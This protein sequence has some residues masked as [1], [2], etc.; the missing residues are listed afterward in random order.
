MNLPPP[1]KPRTRIITDTTPTYTQHRLIRTKFS[2]II[3][4]LDK[5]RASPRLPLAHPVHPRQKPPRTPPATNSTFTLREQSEIPAPIQ[6]GKPFPRKRIRTY[7][8]LFFPVASLLLTIIPTRQ[9]NADPFT[10]A[11]IG[12]GLISQMIQLST[13]GSNPTATFAKHNH[14]MLKLLNDRLT[15]QGV[16]LK[17]ISEQ[18]STLPKQVQTIF[19]QQSGINLRA[20]MTQIA[21]TLRIMKRL[22][23]KNKPLT[24]TL[25]DLK[26]QVDRFYDRIHT[27]IHQDSH[28][29][30]DLLPATYVLDALITFLYGHDPTSLQINRSEDIG[31]IIERIT[32]EL[33]PA[34]ASDLNH[35]TLFDLYHKELLSNQTF[36]INFN[37]FLAPRL[38]NALSETL[39]YRQIIPKDSYKNNK[40]RICIVGTKTSLNPSFD[41]DNLQT[42]YDDQ[43]KIAKRNDLSIT[44]YTF[45]LKLLHYETFIWSS[46][47]RLSEPPMP[48]FVSSSPKSPPGTSYARIKNDALYLG[49]AVAHSVDDDHIVYVSSGNKFYILNPDYEAQLLRDRESIEWQPTGHEATFGN[50]AEF[51]EKFGIAQMMHYPQMRLVAGLDHTYEESETFLARRVSVIEHAIATD[52]TLELAKQIQHTTIPYPILE[53][54]DEPGNGEQQILNQIAFWSYSDHPRYFPMFNGELRINREANWLGRTFGFSAPS[55]RG[56]LPEFHEWFEYYVDSWNKEIIKGSIG[57]DVVW[58]ASIGKDVKNDVEKKIKVFLAELTSTF[59]TEHAVLHDLGVAHDNFKSRPF[60]NLMRWVKGQPKLVDRLA[61]VHLMLYAVVAE[62]QRSWLCARGHRDWYARHGFRHPKTYFGIMQFLITEISARWRAVTQSSARKYIIEDFDTGIKLI[63]SALLLMLNPNY[64]WSTSTT[65]RDVGKS[66]SEA[67]MRTGVNS[68][69]TFPGV[70]VEGEGYVWFHHRN[71]PEELRPMPT[72]RSFEVN[73]QSPKVR[74]YRGRVA[75]AVLGLS[76]VASNALG[77]DGYRRLD[78]QRVGEASEGVNAALDGARQVRAV[79]RSSRTQ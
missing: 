35:L 74:G 40:K 26:L 61:E 45:L 70:M 63:R 33:Y 5:H 59:A 19:V 3:S 29:I 10:V 22:K 23:D 75:V 53:L 72:T 78:P 28:L 4:T 38:S 65:L 49:I 57:N 13:T 64:T 20:S 11:A 31:I 6:P 43:V 18:I 24:H 71:N 15:V 41:V 1:S 9:A 14:E 39:Y 21:R 79:A 54:G 69:E 51:D 30:L 47:L 37:K 17:R 44:L 8:L 56:Q 34:H 16:A 12:L 48:Y 32:K 76:M 60:R 27:V 46:A 42:Y 67:F 36:V 2:Q 77:Q 62:L 68:I 7:L 66:Y 58:V 52:A 25:T 55:C 50:I 73:R